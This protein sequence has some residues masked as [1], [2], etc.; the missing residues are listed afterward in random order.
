MITG[1]TVERLNSQETPGHPNRYRNKRPE[2][3]QTADNKQ[4]PRTEEHCDKS[5][6]E[7]RLLVHKHIDH[8]RNHRHTEATQIPIGQ[9]TVNS[10]GGNVED[11]DF[12]Y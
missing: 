5:Q 2:L 3:N 11:S 8:W 4:T 7:D 10:E 9:L 12:T 1:T 6:R